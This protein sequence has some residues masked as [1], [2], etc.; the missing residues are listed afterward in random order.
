M[1]SQCL[2]FSS[3]SHH[4]KL[5]VTLSRRYSRK[6]SNVTL[7]PSDTE[8]DLPKLS[9][10]KP[11]LKTFGCELFCAGVL[12]MAASVITFINPVLLEWVL[13]FVF[14]KYSR[15]IMYTFQTT[16]L[17]KCRL[18]QTAL[19]FIS[20]VKTVIFVEFLSNYLFNLIVICYPIL[21][22]PITILFPNGK[23]S[24]ENS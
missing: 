19:K 16:I 11:I 22:N 3:C 15:S 10:L 1:H 24:N 17:Q 14:H 6:E 2:Y 8:K 12:K 23:T 20:S 18:C 7:S 5:K 21:S 9:I 13:S 4:H